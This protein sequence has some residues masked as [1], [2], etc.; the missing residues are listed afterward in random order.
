MKTIQSGQYIIFVDDDFELP[1][2]SYI[3]VRP[4]HNNFY[5]NIYSKG[6]PHKRISTLHGYIL[7]GKNIDHI[8]GNGLN[9]QKNNLRFYKSG[10]NMMNQKPHQDTKNRFKGIKR[11][12][13][14]WMAR[15]TLN[16]QEIYLGHYKTDE[17]A[18]K[19]Y[20]VAAKE[21][22]GEFAKTNC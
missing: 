5:A 10:Q 19:A 6:K 18:A 3:R 1:K 22:F 17:E 8:D 7:G 2:N 12:S 14:G 16:K 15:I 4:H 20:D 21:L 11:T 9:N 13:C